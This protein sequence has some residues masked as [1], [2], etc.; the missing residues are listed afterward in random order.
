[1]NNII[2]IESKQ[3]MIKNKNDYVNIKNLLQQN[4]ELVKSNNEITYVLKISYKELKE[5][6]IINDIKFNEI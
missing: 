4:D 2:K 6:M 3:I 1:M 5:F